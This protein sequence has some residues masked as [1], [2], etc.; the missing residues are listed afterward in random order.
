M[1]MSLATLAR[2]KPVCRHLPILYYISG[3][4]HSLTFAPLTFN[5]SLLTFTTF[6]RYF[7]ETLACYEYF[8]VWKPMGRLLGDSPRPVDKSV[9]GAIVFDINEVATHLFLLGVE[10]WLLRPASQIPKS[11]KISYECTPLI[12][13]DLVKED[14]ALDPVC[15]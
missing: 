5:Q 4:Y 13:E 8:T 14:M 9:M 10:V 15:T 2:A 3:S 1:F 11:I 12:L 6:Q 7:L